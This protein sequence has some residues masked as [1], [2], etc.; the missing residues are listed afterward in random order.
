MIKITGMLAL[1]FA[2][3]TVIAGA[4]KAKLQMH[5]VLALLTCLFAVIHFILVVIR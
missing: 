5:Q 1:I 4:T 3:L 2:L